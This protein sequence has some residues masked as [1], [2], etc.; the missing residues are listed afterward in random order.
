MVVDLTYVLSGIKGSVWHIFRHLL[1]KRLIEK[2]ILIKNSR[3]FVYKFILNKWVLKSSIFFRKIRPILDD[4]I[5]HIYNPQ[6][7]RFHLLWERFHAWKLC[8]DLKKYQNIG[9]Y[10]WCWYYDTGRLVVQYQNNNINNVHNQY[11]VSVCLRVTFQQCNAS[12]LAC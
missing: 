6:K 2:L 7:W 11:Y 8:Y 3:A 5:Y 4:N 1:S 10:C 12:W 9:C